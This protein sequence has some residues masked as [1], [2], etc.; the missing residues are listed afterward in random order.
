M[1]YI[2]TNVF[3]NTFDAVAEYVSEKTSATPPR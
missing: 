1:V 3:V 2:K